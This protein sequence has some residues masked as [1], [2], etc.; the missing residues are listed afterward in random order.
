[1]GS[2]DGTRLVVHCV[3]RRA[4]LGVVKRLRGADH[5]VS[6]LAGTHTTRPCLLPAEMREPLSI[7]RVPGAGRFRRL[8][9]GSRE[10]MGVAGRRPGPGGGGLR[11]AVGVGEQ[12]VRGAG[13]GGGERAGIG[14]GRDA[15]QVALGRRGSPAAMAVDSETSGMREPAALSRARR[16]SRAMTR[17]MSARIAGLNRSGSAAARLPAWSRMATPA[18][19][20]RPSFLRRPRTHP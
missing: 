1:M 2:S 9:A 3:S 13:Q 16:S 17:R 12:Q 19:A 15:A 20:G 10:V 7:C 6:G 11:S 5:H 8:P 14:V 4:A 18:G